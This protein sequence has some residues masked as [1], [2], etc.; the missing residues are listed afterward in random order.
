MGSWSVSCGISNIAI[1]ANQKCVLLPIKKGYSESREWGPA[2]LPIFGKYNDYGGIEDI[3]IDDNTKLIEN[4]FGITIDEFCEFLVDGEHFY[5]R[6]EVVE[7]TNKMQN[8][9]EAKEW[10]FMW[11]DRQVYNYM[12]NNYNSHENG[13]MDYGT[14][15]ML[16]KLGFELI[17]TSDSFDNYD[18]KRFNKLWKKGDVEMFSDGRTLL[19]KSGRYVYYFGKG[20]ESS[21]ETYFEVPEE[22][23]YLK[24]SDKY[25]SWKVLNNKE[26]KKLLSFILGSRYGFHED[27]LEEYLRS[28]G[29]ATTPKR[30]TFLWGKYLENLDVFGDAIVGLIHVQQNLHPMSGQF[31]PHILYLTPQCGEHAA[32]QKLLE[33]FAEIN[34]S[35]VR[36]DEEDDDED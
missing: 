25:D 8:N 1:V 13:Y 15:D 5:R 35:Y 22:L 31:Y 17:E 4:H 36:E 10:Q 14:T 27:D 11:V 20:N 26:A 19:S 29:K 21:L 23:V 30:D 9:K 33:K 28:I 32:H 16:T 18:P 12:C 7:I 34:K 3:E 24:N 2:T 6:K